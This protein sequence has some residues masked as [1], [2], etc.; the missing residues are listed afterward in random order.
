MKRRLFALAFFLVLNA[1]A[2]APRALT[3]SAEATPTRVAV[4]TPGVG[5]KFINHTPPPY[6]VNMTPFQNVKCPPPGNASGECDPNNPLASFG[7]DEIQKPSDALGAL[8]PSFPI[9]LCFVVPA[10]RPDHQEPPPGSYL[11]RQGGLLG[12]YAR[13]LI[14]R[15]NEFQVLQT[16]EELKNTF[17]PIESPDEALAYAIAVKGLDAV[18]GL[19]YEPGYA[20]SVDVIEDSF[21]RPDGDGY[22]VRLFHFR[23]FGCGP[24]EM[25]AFDLRVS[26]DGTIQ[27]VAQQAMYRDPKMDGLCID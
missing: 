26:R 5:P 18:Y 23:M 17:A 25:V 27:D 14:Q 10:R 1:C 6:T 13:Y 15:D 12:M 2:V 16:P 9:V 11:Y 4:S 7:C 24:H 21:A 3:P 22:V 19:K 20:Y 8:N